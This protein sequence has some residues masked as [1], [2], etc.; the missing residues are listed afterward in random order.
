LLLK[1][2]RLKGSGKGSAQQP[3]AERTYGMSILNVF[4]ILV[5][6]PPI[7]PCL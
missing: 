1:P 2:Q 3:P 7:Y 5:G 6:L 4:H